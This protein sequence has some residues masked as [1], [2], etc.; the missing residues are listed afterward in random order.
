M[1]ALTSSDCGCRHKMLAMHLCHNCA[2]TYATY[3]IIVQALMPHLCHN[4]QALTSSDPLERAQVA[5]QLLQMQ[6]GNGLMHES[7]SAANPRRCTRPWFEWANAMLVV[8]AGAGRFGLRVEG[9][10]SCTV[11]VIVA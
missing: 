5:R 11:C 4:V 6:C 7:V 10:P 1:Q 8:L 9:C 2:G 3:A